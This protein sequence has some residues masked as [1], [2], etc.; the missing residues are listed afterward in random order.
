MKISVIQLSVLWEDKELNLRKLGEMMIPLL[1]NTDIVVLPEMF[2]TGFSMNPERLSESAGGNTLLWMKKKASEGNF[3]LCGSYIAEENGNY[4]NRWTFVTP[5]GEYLTYD[6]RHLFSFAGEDKYFSPGRERLV[7]SFRGTRIFPNICYDLRF[8]VWCRNLNDYDLMINSA[9]WP[10]NRRDVWLTLLKA[11]A[12]E[13]QCYVAGANVT[14]TDGNNI[15]YSGDSVII[16]PRGNILSSAFS[17][18]DVSIS[19]DISLPELEVF[20]K[21]F[22]FLRDADIFSIEL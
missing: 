12:I 2:S 3:G 20:R 7:F 13:N 19:Y 8:P 15:A 6:K 14:G 16:G 18:V 11:R 17:D 5:S 1:N 10:E 9:N 4:Y 21:N 22:P